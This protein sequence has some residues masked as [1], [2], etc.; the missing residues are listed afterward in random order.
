MIRR[1]VF[2]NRQPLLGDEQQ[3][4]PEF[5]LLHLIACTHPFTIAVDLS[6]L[7]GREIARTQRPPDLLHVGYKPR[8]NTF[9]DL[10]IWVGRHEVVVFVLSV[11]TSGTLPRAR[12]LPGAHKKCSGRIRCTDLSL[13]RL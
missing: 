3:A 4:L 1:K 8:H 13:A 9:C 5:E 12:S 2:R 10:R 11:N 6:L 7:I